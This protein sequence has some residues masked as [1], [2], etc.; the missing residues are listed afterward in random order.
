MKN[1]DRWRNLKDEGLTDK[2]IEKT[3]SQKVRMKV[4]AWNPKK[5]TDTTMTPMDSIKYHRQ[6]MQS[7]F[8]VMDPN[9]G[10]IKAWVGG[11]DFKTYKFD[12]ASLKTKRQ[13]GSAIKALFYCQSIEE[14][15]FTP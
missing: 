15:E 10:E 5:S 14:I 2:E 9:T 13:V 8:I 6:M 1:S 4:F 11:I 12:H 3:F 7:S